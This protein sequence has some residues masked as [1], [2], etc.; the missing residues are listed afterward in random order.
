MILIRRAGML[1]LSPLL[2]LVCRVAAQQPAD[3]AK[4]D[5][6]VADTV[7][8]GADAP[9]AFGSGVDTSSLAAA[10]TGAGEDSVTL[11]SVPDSS[12]GGWKKN[13]R[14]AY[15]NDPA[16]WHHGEQPSHGFANWLYRV[17]TS[18]GFRYFVLFVL[19][20]VLL[21]VIVRVMSENN[22]GI[23]YNRRKARTRE[24]DGTG[25]EHDPEEDVDQGLQQALASGDHRRATRYLYLRT[26]RGLSDRG[27][28]R[29]TIQATNHD[30][31]RQLAGTRQE[32]SF[33]FL[34]L[35]YEKVWYGDFTLAEGQFQRLHQHFVDFEKTLQP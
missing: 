27:L 6:I 4:L 28:I 7:V 35:A 19:G 33:R 12:V 1:L 34:T 29:P 32:A 5:T 2:F 23:F 21:F 10:A 20:G 22:F 13:P 9:P 25:D 14:F 31:L 24:G 16:Y 18:A 30:Y 3:T 17:L 11:R 8:V 15:A 26:L